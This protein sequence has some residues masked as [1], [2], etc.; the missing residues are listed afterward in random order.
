MI[1]PLLLG[2]NFSGNTGMTP[3]SFNP[4]NR[5]KVA[6]LEYRGYQV[7]DAVFK[8]EKLENTGSEKIID[9][10]GD[11]VDDLQEWCRAIL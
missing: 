4:I 6:E 7:T 9:L 10:I 8:K 3:R 5:Y 11:M 2:F 1:N